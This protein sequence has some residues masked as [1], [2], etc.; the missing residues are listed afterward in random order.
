MAIVMLITKYLYKLYIFLN[1]INHLFEFGKG[2]I[3]TP[4]LILI[5][6]IFVDI[7]LPF[8]IQTQLSQHQ[9]HLYTYHKLVELL[10]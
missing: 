4:P 5:T 3:F 1:N 7:L 2:G 9:F 8:A 10:L 6:I